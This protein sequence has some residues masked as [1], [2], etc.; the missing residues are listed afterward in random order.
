MKPNR[1]YFTLNKQQ[2]QNIR[3]MVC[4]LKKKKNTQKLFTLQKLI[5]NC[6]A[7][8]IMIS[9]KTFLLWIKHYL[10]T[11]I[12]LVFFLFKENLPVGKTFWLFLQCKE[13]SQVSFYFEK[14]QLKAPFKRVLYKQFKKRGWIQLRKERFLKIQT[15]S[16]PF[17]SKLI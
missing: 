13:A 7:R 16:L 6:L 11:G 5:L 10:E 17:Y 1:P 9:R 12:I 3:Q 4:R 2:Q 15:L 8:K 14:M